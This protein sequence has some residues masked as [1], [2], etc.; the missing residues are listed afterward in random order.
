LQKGANPN[1]NTMPQTMAKIEIAT[2]IGD[3][4]KGEK[5]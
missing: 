4:R 1:I 3:I 2:F 5:K